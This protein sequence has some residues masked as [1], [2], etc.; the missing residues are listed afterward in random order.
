MPNVISE[1]ESNWPDWRVYIRDRCKCVY[2]GFD[3]TG[4]AASG[5]LQI[6]HVRVCCTD[7][8]VGVLVWLA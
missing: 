2:C 6:D 3:S 8:V 1:A 4:F 5:H 7:R